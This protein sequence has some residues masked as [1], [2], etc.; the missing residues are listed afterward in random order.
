M[1][2]ASNMT[3][4]RRRLPLSIT[5]W[6]RSSTKSVPWFTPTLHSPGSNSSAT[7]ISSLPFWKNTSTGICILSF[8]AI[9]SNSWKKTSL[10]RT[11]PNTNHTKCSITV[12][13]SFSLSW[14]MT[15]VTFYLLSHCIYVCTFLRNSSKSETWSSQHILKTWSSKTQVLSRA[16]RNSIINL[17]WSTCPST[18]NS[19]LTNKNTTNGIHWFL[20]PLRTRTKKRTLRNLEPRLKHKAMNPFN[21][22]YCTFLG[23][24]VTITLSSQPTTV[25]NCSL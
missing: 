6:L 22:S 25:A 20:A 12:S 8:C 19:T 10:K 14:F 21:F 4:Q 2:P 17:T 3:S 13:S 11:W 5:F 18:T 9:Y 23:I 16:D 1:L 15:S 24:K 7:N